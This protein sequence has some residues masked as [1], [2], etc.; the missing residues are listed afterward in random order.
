M[1]SARIKGEKNRL[2]EGL[3]LGSIVPRCQALESKLI[4]LFVGWNGAVF[5]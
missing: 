5:I 4:F 2:Q 3:N 1:V